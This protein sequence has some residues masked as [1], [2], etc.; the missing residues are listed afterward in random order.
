MNVDVITLRDDAM[1]EITDGKIVCRGVQ[2]VEYLS[3]GR[4]S[5]LGARTEVMFTP[6][7][8]YKVFTGIAIPDF[9]GVNVRATNKMFGKG[10]MVVRV[11]MGSNG[12][13]IPYITVLEPVQ[14]VKNENMFEV[15][16]ST[17]SVPVNSIE[18]RQEKLAKVEKV[19]PTVMLKEDNPN[20]P[21]P[22]QKVPDAKKVEDWLNS[23][24]E[25]V[26]KVVPV[27][28]VKT[29][30]YEGKAEIKKAT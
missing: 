3:P 5:V 8:I 27:I 25:K 7:I 22:M 23:S 1:A 18:L 16:A 24:D 30:A 11:D 19:Y 20:T 15:T 29:K 26:V 9:A 12:E 28:E 14:F 10:M 4:I 2:I 17:G 6:G 13:I 21:P